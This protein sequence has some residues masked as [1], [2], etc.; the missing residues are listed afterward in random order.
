MINFSWLRVDLHD[1]ID[2]EACLILLIIICF[3]FDS[4]VLLFLMLGLER[5]QR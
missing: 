3:A 5:F 2:L 4:A 1:V